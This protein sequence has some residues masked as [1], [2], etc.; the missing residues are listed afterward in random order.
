VPLTLH[1]STNI[2]VI[3]RFLDVEFSV[4][5]ADGAVVVEVAG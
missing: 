1:S 4:T 2:D 5:P 3:R